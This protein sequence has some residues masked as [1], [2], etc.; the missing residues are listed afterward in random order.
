[1]GD[2]GEGKDVFCSDQINHGI[3]YK[4]KHTIALYDIA[5][6]VPG[7]CLLIPRR[8]MI[9]IKEA[10]EEELSDLFKTLKKIRPVILKLYGDRSN[11]YNFTA[12]IG[13][14]SGMSVM[15]LH[16]HFIPR[17]KQDP[18]QRGK[19]VYSEIERTRRISEGD[20]RKEVARLRKELKWSN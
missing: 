2:E 19:S 4:T 20:Y 11:S 7:H 17:R 12:Q 1:M 18:F 8:H 10:S 5:P 14:Y 6:V 3:F 9:D 15:H 13:R 16:F